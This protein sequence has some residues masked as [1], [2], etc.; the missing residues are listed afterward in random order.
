MSVAQVVPSSHLGLL[1][2]G[3][4]SDGDPLQVLDG[5]GAVGPAV[6]VHDPRGHAGHEA[7]YRVAE[8]L[9]GRQHRRE[10]DE[11]GEGDLQMVDGLHW[12]V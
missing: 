10:Q 2:L 12:V 7:V 9:L 4:R 3:G 6:G 1:R 11:D 5:V 8:V